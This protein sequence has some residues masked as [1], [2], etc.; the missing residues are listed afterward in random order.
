Y[1]IRP[2]GGRGATAGDM[3]RV[4]VIRLPRI[5]N[6][7]DIDALALEPGVAVRF[8]T[9]QAELAEADLVVVPGTGAP[10]P[11]PAGPR[12]HGL[13]VALKRRAAERKPVLAICGGYQMLGT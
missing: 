6:F 2:A 11:D 3:L 9:T 10:V 5:S 12:R 7:T 1:A 13:D 4:A 8:A